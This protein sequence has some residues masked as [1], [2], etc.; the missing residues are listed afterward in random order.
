MK[1][2]AALLMLTLAVTTV[3]LFAAD[4]SGKWTGEVPR[5][6]GGADKTTFDIHIDGDKVSGS[7][8][9]PAA[10]YPIKDGR[11]QDDELKFYILVNMGRDVKFIYTGKLKGEEIAFTREI[12]SMG[13]LT[14]FIARRAR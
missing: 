10:T 9:T 3:A 14:G 12:Q 4:V 11:F 8:T 5:R 13:I 7:V 1:R 6:N 2:F